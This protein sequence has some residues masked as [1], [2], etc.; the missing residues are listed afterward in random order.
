MKTHYV[1]IVSI[2]VSLN[3]AIAYGAAIAEKDIVGSWQ[4]GLVGAARNMPVG[5]AFRSGVTSAVFTFL[6]DKTMR[7]EVPCREE[8]FI[9]ENG[10]IL[11]TGTWELKKDGTLVQ[12]LEA[13]D[14][15]FKGEK[16]VE[17]VSASLELDAL[18]LTQQDG[19]KTQLGRF[20]ADV[21]AAC[22]YE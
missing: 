12:R 21:K 16:L 7:M 1:P 10:E 18:V 11:L 4:V 20:A 22:K 17:T 2:W 14:G 9:R 6:P 13:K 3:A 19:Q 8:A 15:K 5:L